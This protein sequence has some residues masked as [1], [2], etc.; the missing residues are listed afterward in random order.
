M[1]K[2]ENPTMKIK[3]LCG[4]TTIVNVVPATAYCK[5]TRFVCGCK[6]VWHIC[7]YHNGCITSSL[8]SLDV[9]K[10]YLVL[11]EEWEKNKELETDKEIEEILNPKNDS[12]EWPEFEIIKDSVVDFMSDLPIEVYEHLY[13]STKQRQSELTAYLLKF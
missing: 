10:A 3:C 7:D 4:K 2:K 9:D 5:I 1:P 11:E 13:K 6:R 12:E 8:V